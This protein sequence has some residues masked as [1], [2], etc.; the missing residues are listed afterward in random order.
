M[1]KKTSG[2]WSTVP[3]LKDKSFFPNVVRCSEDVLSRR[4]SVTHGVHFLL[5][6]KHYAPIVQRTVQYNT[7]FKD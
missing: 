2:K 7:A 3:D 4:L 5:E 1:E 6:V